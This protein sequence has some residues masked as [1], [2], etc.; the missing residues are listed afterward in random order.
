VT[1]L[2]TEAVASSQQPRRRGIAWAWSATAITMYC[3]LFGAF[4][5]T[6]QL[7]VNPVG[8]RQT[9]DPS[10]VDQATWF[11]RYAATAV[12]HFRL[13]ALETTTM[14]AP[15]SVNLMWNTS[16]PL[17]SIVV[18]PVTLLFGPQVA[19]TTL[20]ALGF[21]GSA[22]AMYYVLRRWHA[23]PIAATLGGALYGFSPAL[24][25]SGIG[26]Y[27]LVVA[28]LLPLIVDRVLRMVAGQDSPVRNGLWLGVLVAA[29]LFT[30]EESLVDAVIATVILLAVLAISRPR[31][32]LARVRPVLAGMATAAVVALVLCAR[33]LWVQFHGIAAK[34]AAATV[35]INYHGRPTNLGTLPYALVNPASSVLLHTHRSGV[36][37]NN[38]PQPLPEYLAYLGVP[39]IILLIVA[40]VYF[41]RDLTIR[42]L[43]LTCLLLEWVGMGAKPIQANQVSLPAVLLPWHFLEHLPV[44]EGMVPDRLCILADAAAGAVLAFALDK[45]RSGQVPLFARMRH[46]AAVAAGIAVLALLPLAPAPYQV[47]R[48]E[49][50]PAGWQA[51]FAALHLTPQDRVLL[52]PFP[53]AATSQTM[54]WQAMSTNPQTMI[55]GDFIAPNQPGRHSRAGRS[56][57]TPTAYYIDYLYNHQ[58]PAPRPSPAQIQADL[59]LWKPAAVVARTTP[60]SELGQFLISLFGQPTTRNGQMLGWL[61]IGQQ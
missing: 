4:V 12:S 35:I 5:V 23:S 52:A 26:H 56:A 58:V 16:L 2:A 33:A 10:D 31:E 50:L 55:G 17:P 9:G 22:A 1:R 49:P 34:G 48:T 14:N 24:V 41:W 32:V 47:A 45:A 27:S 13:P 3:Y 8:F 36:I 40:I 38:Y 39:M 28:F 15:H 60:G 37:A 11:V 19:L 29:Q 57:M 20:L 43:G 61:V 44:I 53:Y 18:S 6:S 25:N 21:A 46:G 51:T 7:W 54:R 42:S 30:S 59:A